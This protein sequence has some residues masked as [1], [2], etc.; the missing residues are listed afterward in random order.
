MIGNIPEVDD[1]LY[2]LKGITQQLRQFEE[3]LAIIEK[4]SAHPAAQPS[5][6][7]YSLPPRVAAALARYGRGLPRETRIGMMTEARARLL[8]GEDE[9]AVIS[10]IQSGEGTSSPVAQSILASI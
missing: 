4:A 6:D 9:Q 2:V 7:S 3:R 1:I 5:G 8:E 10:A